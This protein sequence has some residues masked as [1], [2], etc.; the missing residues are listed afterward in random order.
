MVFKTLNLGN[1]VTSVELVILLFLNAIFLKEF[2]NT[3]EI[4][5]GFLILLSIVIIN[6]YSLKEVK[7]DP[8]KF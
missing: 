7:Q 4:I 8:C 5:G 3:T 1:I 2:P 6:F